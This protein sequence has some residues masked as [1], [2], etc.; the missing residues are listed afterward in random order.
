MAPHPPPPTPQK[1]IVQ[2]VKQTANMHASLL[3]L[4]PPHNVSGLF[5]LIRNF[6]F[7]IMSKKEISVTALNV[8]WQAIYLK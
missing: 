5:A 7:V 6:N 1:K 2:N 8:Q 4:L 3:S